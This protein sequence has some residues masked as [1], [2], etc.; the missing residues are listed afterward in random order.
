MKKKI[1][2][3][4]KKFF[5][6]LFVVGIFLTSL[7]TGLFVSEVHALSNISGDKIIEVAQSYSDW[8]YG[9]VGTCTGLVT[10]T[11]N[12]LGIGTS[13]VGIHPYDINTKQPDGTGARYAPAAMYN[14]ALNHPEDA[15]HIWSGYVKDVKANASL[16]R[17]GDLVIQRPEDKAN[18]TGSG[19]VGFI[20][21]YSDKISMYGANGYNYGVSDAVMATGVTAGISLL[22]TSI[23]VNSMDYIHV[24]RLTEVEPIYETLDSTKTAEEKVEVT[25]HK[26]DVESGKP[27]SGV[28]VDFYRDGVKFSSGITDSNGNASS[29][30]VVT[31]SS[32]S[33]PKTYV[34]NWDD[35]GDAGKAEVNERGAYHSRLEA[36]A[37]ADAE[38]QSAATRKASQTHTYTVIETKTKTKYW[39]N[40][41]NNTV[42]DKVTGSGSVKVSLTNERV[43][44]TA[45]LYK[46]DADVKHGQNESEIDGAVYGLYASENILDPADDS[47]IYPKGTEI[48]KVRIAEGTA[49]V[50]DLYLGDYEWRE[51]TAGVGYS[52]DPTVHKFSLT[53][54]NQDTKIVTNKTTSKENVIVGDF[55][56]EK[57][58][59]SGDESEI[60]E[61]EEGAEFLVVAKK[62]V[63][64]YGSI[65]EAWNHKDEYTEK[66]YDKLVT[67]SKGYA[68][69]RK[70]AYGTFIVK[71]VKGKVDTDMVKNTWEFKVARENQDTI[72]YIINNR[73]FTSYV[74]LVKRD[75]DTDKLITMSNT[76]FKIKNAET[77]E[78]LKQKVADK[79]YD[80]W[81]TSDKGFFQ[82]PLEVKA[83]DWILEEIESPD[84]Y[85]IN[86][87]GQNFKV[88]NSNVVEVDEDGDPILTVTMYDQA[89]KGQVKVEKKGEVL[90]GVKKDENGNT[91]FV[92][93]EKCLAG[94][95]VYIQAD[96]DI[97]DVA[98]GSI[99]Y[100]KGDIV[101]K[102]TTTCEAD[103]LSKELPLGKY[104]AYEYEAPRGM[105]VDT[106]K[107]KINLEFKDNVTPIIVE[108]LS[109]TN[110]RQK[111]ELNL[112]KLDLD[113]E[114]PLEGVI[115]N[116][117]AIKDILSYDGEV[118]VKAGD[119]IEIG[120]TDSKGKYVFNAD[121][122]LSF[123][124][125]TYFE[126]SEKKELN[127]YYKNE[128]K[129]SVD[130]KYKGQN[131]EKI[132]NSEKIFNEAIKN[133]VLINKV[134]D[135]TLENII[136]KDFSF[137][138]CKDE[139]CEEVVDTYKANTEDGTALIPIY[140][141]TWY[142]SE[143]EA[144]E[145]YAISS[146]IVKI[147]LNDEGLFINDK[148]VETDED[149]LYSI[150]YQ[151]TLLPVVQIDN[152][153]Q[154]GYENNKTLYLVIG[155]VSLA[156]AIAI[157]ISL[158]KKKKRK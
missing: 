29:T 61:K 22:G 20:H 9:E 114:T 85:L 135:K 2:M 10:R 27:L 15:K 69:T 36:Q 32:T 104:V 113:R 33:S 125:E 89:V 118:L 1:G 146:E 54:A 47:V 129:I 55:E 101:D 154:T 79:T 128:E 97:I 57:I 136:S 122:P 127:G 158:M 23:N 17:N 30:S 49:K 103:A 94:M 110:E 14:N 86:Q 35:L 52:V 102:V 8:G 38:A 31:H 56:L 98:D 63:D 133:Y 76:T 99:I 34:T 145:G 100:K 5:E 72:K 12:K 96:E 37:A 77:G 144:P 81:K 59:T 74:K 91:K 18:Y 138:L 157:A 142:A 143:Y 25:F 132:S 151:D 19:H 139:K 150:K 84:F 147:T 68:K 109:I 16:F 116:L 123:D 131:I 6:A 82:L 115:F 152:G 134:D 124:D 3:K 121:L 51:L 44:G 130:T 60:V 95:T 140:Y 4:L 87:E 42:S 155:G 7:P 41:E 117:K 46:E 105:L 120:T 67:S 43:R 92:Y 11:L 148:L 78:Y 70:L 71:Q 153:V 26:A 39:L 24:F 111:V 93:E 13:V 80:T 90:T 107:Y 65:E 75:K 21:I 141:G 45:Y 149:L 48:T 58:I 64:K 106:N 83:G 40:P 50:E 137:R 28:E 53:Y 62:Y 73:N 119:V 108:T 126:I 88:T 66:E 112:T 156:G